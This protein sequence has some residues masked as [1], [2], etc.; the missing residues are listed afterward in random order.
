MGETFIDGGVHDMTLNIG[1]YGQVVMTL[2]S[3]NTVVVGFGTD[4]RPIEPVRIGYYPGLCN[5]LG[6]P[7]NKVPELPKPVCEE[8]LQCDGL[9]AQCYSGGG[10]NHS[11]PLPGGDQCIACFQERMP[12]NFAKFPESK[13]MVENNCPKGEAARKFMECFCHGPKNS[14]GEVSNPFGRW[15]TTTTTTPVP[16]PSPPWPRRPVPPTPAPPPPCLFS[17]SCLNML[18]QKGCHQNL[19]DGTGAYKCYKCMY[20]H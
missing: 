2:P 10:W 8:V 7:C 4:L 20:D 12:L 5:V 16:V 13:P 14:G 9:V 17:E 11:E 15:P 19:I 3:V 1:L 18:N 6:I